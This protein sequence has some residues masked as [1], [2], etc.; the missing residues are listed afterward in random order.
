MDYGW[1]YAARS[2]SDASNSG[3]RMIWGV[4]AIDVT[5]EAEARPLN[6][7]HSSLPREVSLAED[8]TTV[9]YTQT[10]LTPATSLAP[11]SLLA[12]CHSQSCAL[13]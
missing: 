1:W 6:R 13:L 5:Q 8:G 9:V 3:R 2:T 7:L 11:C 4:I 12:T 10:G